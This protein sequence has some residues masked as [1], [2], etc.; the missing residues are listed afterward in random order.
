MGGI[1]PA[2][3]VVAGILGVFLWPLFKDYG[4]DSSGFKHSWPWMLTSVGGFN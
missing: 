2:V 3:G 4:S 1:R